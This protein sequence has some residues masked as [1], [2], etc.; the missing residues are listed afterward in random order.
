VATGAASKTAWTVSAGVEGLVG[1]FPA[2]VRVLFGLAD[3]LLTDRARELAW[4]DGDEPAAGIVQEA[5]E[6]E[7]P[8]MSWLNL[9]EVANQLE[10]RQG[11]D[12]ANEVVRR[13]RAALLLDDVTPERVLAAARIKAA[14]PI[15]FADYFA[16]ATAAAHRATLFT[17][18]PDLLDRKLGCRTRDLRPKRR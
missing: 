8:V 1:G 2:E 15:A 5:L 6:K 12:E 10:R 7:R 16:T 13:L 3:A 9:G 14:H 17:G 4:L 11:V 18:V